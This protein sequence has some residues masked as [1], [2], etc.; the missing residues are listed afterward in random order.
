MS[1]QRLSIETPRSREELQFCS[2]AN[3]GYSWHLL[4]L[5]KKLLARHIHIH[6]S[7]RRH[8]RNS[9]DGGTAHK[10]STKTIR[11]VNL[12]GHAPSL[13][14][15]QTN[16]L[17]QRLVRITCEALHAATAL[18]L[19]AEANTSPVICVAPPS[20]PH[21]SRLPALPRERPARV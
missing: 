12:V 20:C 7:P 21:D 2:A 10:T 3:L 14:M 15:P 1:D 8:L 17:F 19:Q 13:L 11:L 4:L 18:L 16:V 9:S 6:S 5:D